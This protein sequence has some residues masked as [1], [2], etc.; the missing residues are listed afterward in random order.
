MFTDSG[1]GSSSSPA[2]RAF[3]EDAGRRAFRIIGAIASAHFRTAEAHT[4]PASLRR[5]GSIANAKRAPSTSAV[6]VRDAS[7]FV[8]SEDMR[9]AV[10]AP[11]DA[12]RARR[13]ARCTPGSVA[14]A[15]SAVPVCRNSELG[16]KKNT[17]TSL[18]MPYFT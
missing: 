2:S 3:A 16:R 14:E 13:L 6:T 1:A 11:L 7:A 17:A 10:G 18:Q 12:T 5:S 4:T 8:A 9:A 15:T